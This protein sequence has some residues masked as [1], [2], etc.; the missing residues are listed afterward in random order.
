MT[1]TE[2]QSRRAKK[3]GDELSQRE[4]FIETARALGCDESD[5]SYEQLVKNLAAQPPQPRKPKKKGKRNG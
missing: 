5:V 3:S 1:K 4:K 2:Q